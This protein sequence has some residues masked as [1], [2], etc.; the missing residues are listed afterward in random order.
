MVLPTMLLLPVGVYEFLDDEAQQAAAC[1]SRKTAHCKTC[2]I[3]RPDVTTWSR[4]EGGTI[5]RRH[6]NRVKFM[7]PA[8]I[9]Y[10]E[11]IFS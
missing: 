5:L 10:L 7:F 9:V 11:I 6:V 4:S 8:K 2:D 3:K 1:R